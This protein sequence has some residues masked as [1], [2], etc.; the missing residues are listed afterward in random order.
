MPFTIAVLVLAVLVSSLR[1]GRL[2]RLADAPLRWSW[3]L[4]VGLG[5]QV[6]V[7]LAAATGPFGDTQLVGTIALLGSQVLVAAW[8]V[9]NRALPGM[10]LIAAGLAMNAVVVAANGAMPVD[11]AAI[12]ALGLDGTRVPI[13]RHTLLSD[14]T[15]LAWLAD[16][17][18]LVWLRSIVSPG[19]VVLAIGLFPLMHALLTYRPTEQRRRSLLADQRG[20]AA[21]VA[22]DPPADDPPTD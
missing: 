5:L 17:W 14:A 6:G 7:D 11:P 2:Y 3:L 12:D 8:L 16:V 18:P 4:L 19:D 21:E 10:L 1:G 20:Q 13:G 22:D 15:R 9:R